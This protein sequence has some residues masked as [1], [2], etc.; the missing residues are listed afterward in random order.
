LAANPRASPR[1]KTL[2]HALLRALHAHGAREI[3]GIPGDFALPFFDAIEASGLLPLYTLSHEPSVGFAADASA[4]IRGEMSV[5][6]VTYGAGALNLVNPIAAAY[7]EKSP[8]VVV[9]GAPGAHER[10]SGLLLHH[11]ARTLDSQFAIY[12]EI[13]CAQARLD[14]PAAAP[15]EIARVLAAARRHSRPVYLEIPRDAAELPSAEVVAAE[16]P[17]V[18]AEAV[19]AC[20]ADVLD[21]LAGARNPV[22]MV[23]VE[24]RRFGLESKVERLAATLR[25]PVV[26]SFMGRGLL[27]GATAPL[28]GTY[29]AGAG[30]PAICAL[31]EESDG[32]L[33]LGVIA[34]DINFGIS[35]RRVDV[36]RAIHACDGCVTLSHHTYSQVPLAALVDALLDCA[37]ALA[38]A[39]PWQRAPALCGLADDARPVTPADVA[40]GLN[41]LM[42]SGGRFPVAADV[43][44]CLF[45]AMDLEPT[46]YVA[47]GYYAGMGFG[48]PA[49]LGLQA[50]TGRRP[51]A[52]VGDG[53]FQMTG[54]EL[55]HCRRYGWDPIVVVLNN[56]GWGMLSAFRPEAR[57]TDLGE[58]NFARLADALG[59]RGARVAT[60]GELKRALDAAARDRGRFQLLDVRIAPDALSPALARFARAANR[61]HARPQPG[62]RAQ[63]TSAKTR[64][65]T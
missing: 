15:A 64:N 61:A 23:G 14:D 20:A 33:L 13:T 28:A 34:S 35:P 22:L 38:A 2:A 57:Y 60:R 62:A 47:P 46:D 24:V 30:D 12:R 50:A 54:W 8:V 42:A 17:P 49:A 36:R 26:T 29:L 4:R 39:T 27:A 58:W 53:A 45:A 32:L 59:G 5:A 6:A 7:A 9:S 19:A 63:R 52:L 37:R 65:T 44:D 31:V 48:V 1:V 43:G 51:V 41:D 55:G 25:V 56:G 18:D 3:F 10:A 40:A 16:E 21:R 11:Q